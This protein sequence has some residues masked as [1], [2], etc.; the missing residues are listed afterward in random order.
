MLKLSPPTRDINIAN[1]ITY[2]PGDFFVQRLNQEKV[3]LFIYLFFKNLNQEDKAATQVNLFLPHFYPPASYDRL[4]D[5][6]GSSEWSLSPTQK[7]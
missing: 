5:T 1:H 4:K 6:F 3:Y 2:F 7:F